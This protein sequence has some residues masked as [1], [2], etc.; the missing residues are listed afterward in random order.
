MDFHK[1][2]LTMVKHVLNQSKSTALDTIS[3][4]CTKGN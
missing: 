4:A 2:Q 1:E 3:H